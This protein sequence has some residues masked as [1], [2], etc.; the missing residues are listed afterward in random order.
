MDLKTRYVV[1]GINKE[2]TI[3]SKVNIFYNEAT[4]KITKVEDKWDGQ[5][6]DS[7]FRDVSGSTPAVCV[8]LHVFSLATYKTNFHY[9]GCFI[10]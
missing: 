7:S 9:C 6:P 10:T 5:L 8:A 4:G 3:E 1:K 2:Q